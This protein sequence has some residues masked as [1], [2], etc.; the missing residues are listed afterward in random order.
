MIDQAINAII[1]QLNN[2]IGAADPEVILG[3]ISLIDAFQ[4]SSSQ[5]LSDKVIASVVN[6]EQ[7]ESLRNIPFRR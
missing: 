5:S 6:I 4:D 3:N 2:Y 1:A 7:E